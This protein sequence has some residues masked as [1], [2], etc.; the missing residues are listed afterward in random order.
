MDSREDSTGIT[1]EQI[2][3]LGIAKLQEGVTGYCL[4]IDIDIPAYN[5]QNDHLAGS[6]LRLARHTC[7]LFISQ[8]L[9]EDGITYLVGHLV[10]MAFRNGFR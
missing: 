6:N 9:V 5:T 4:Q 2:Y 3:S 7:L 8:E 10:G 1:V